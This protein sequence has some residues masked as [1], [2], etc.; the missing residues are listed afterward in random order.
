MS[1]RT[2]LERAVKEKHLE[3]NKKETRQENLGESC[4]MK[5]EK[6]T[7]LKVGVINNRYILRRDKKE[8]GR[9]I[10]LDLASRRSDIC[11]ENCFRG[12]VGAEARF[13]IRFTNEYKAGKPS[14]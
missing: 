9:K 8:T 1:F 2:E 11:N 10:P 6:E 13:T 3:N 14:E 5:A 7:F 4:D 12:G